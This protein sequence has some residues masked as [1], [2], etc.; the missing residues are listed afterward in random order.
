MKRVAI[1]LRTSSQNQT[2]ENQLIPLKEYA[3][4]C[5]YEIVGVYEDWGVSGAKNSR[6]SLDSMLLD[7]RRRKFSIILA[8]SICRI[9]RNTAHLCSIMEEM[10]H[11]GIGLYF[12]Q[13]AID[14]TQIA[15]KL[16]FQIIASIA[17]FERE[18]IRSRIIAGQNRARANG[19]KLGRPSSMT[20]SLKS[21]IQLL[22]EKGM[23][24]KEIS[25]TV[26]CGVGTV[27]SV[28]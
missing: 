11:L 27:Y 24:I 8:W 17:E 6:P 25:R 2:C 28:I 23:G 10:N 16:F 26:K 3:Q 4:R 18:M 9:G 1:Y 19:K 15:G 21:A 22:R 14:T 5:G 12:H 13:S 20:P 7:A